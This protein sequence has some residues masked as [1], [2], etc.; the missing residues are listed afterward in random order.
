MGFAMTIESVRTAHF[1]WKFHFSLFMGFAVSVEFVR[2][3]LV[4][5]FWSAVE[6]FV[7]CLLCFEA[8]LMCLATVETMLF[9][10]MF[11]EHPF[12]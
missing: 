4:R 2:T 6:P 11:L 12:L 10:V 5:R 3:A 8:Y 7:I 9:S 1:A